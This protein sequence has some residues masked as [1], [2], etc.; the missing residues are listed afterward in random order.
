MDVVL[1]QSP[2]WDFTVHDPLTGQV[3]DAD[4]LPT[5][6]VFENATDVPILNPLVVRRV[7]MVGNYR[8]TFAATAANGFEYGKS[9]NV[10]VTATV[11]AISAKSRIAVFTIENPPLQ[12][13]PAFVL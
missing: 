11:T 8:T 12:P 3:M 7:G 10:I 4:F 9:Y 1:G 2:T 5:C 6:Q 13:Q